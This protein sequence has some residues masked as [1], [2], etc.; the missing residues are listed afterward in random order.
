MAEVNS[1][2]IGGFSIAAC[3]RDVIKVGRGFIPRHREAAYEM[4]PYGGL[5]NTMTT[6]TAHGAFSQG[7]C[8]SIVGCNRHLKYLWGETKR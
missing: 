2:Q 6:I 5:P 1:Y 4:P 7:E 3:L 8:R